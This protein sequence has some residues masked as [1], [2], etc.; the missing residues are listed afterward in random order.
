MSDLPTYQDIIPISTRVVKPDRMKLERM[1][2]FGKHGVFEE[3]RRLGQNWFVDLDLQVD[4]QQAGV[5]DNLELSINYAFI[6][7]VVKAIVEQESHL[8]VERLTERIAT[9]LLATFPLINEA[10]VRVTKPNPPFDIHFSGVTI[11]MT[12]ARVSDGGEQSS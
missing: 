1:A 5:S 6:H 3:E 12:R 7:E 10:T 11:E 4:M 9:V 2:F 8:L